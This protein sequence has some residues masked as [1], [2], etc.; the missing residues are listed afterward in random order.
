MII[1]VEGMD[2]SGKT[3]LCQWLAKK[4]LAMYVKAERPPARPNVSAYIQTI[5]YAEIYAGSVICDRVPFISEPIYGTVLCGGHRLS[6]RDIQ[7]GIMQAYRIIYCR[8]PDSVILGSLDSREQ[9]EGVVENSRQLLA[10]YDKCF[11]ELQSAPV[12]AYDYTSCSPQSL[13]DSLLQR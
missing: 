5:R 10:A 7:Q 12:I 2:N 1:F 9:M 4:L 13:F 3:T 11:T 8:P 6:S